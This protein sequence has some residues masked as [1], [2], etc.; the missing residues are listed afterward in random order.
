MSAL[1]TARIIGPLVLSTITFGIARAGTITVPEGTVTVTDAVTPVG[2]L[3]QYDYTI[4]DGTG[5]LAVLDIAVTPG[6]DISGL[7]APGGN[8]DFTSTV[9]TANTST[10]TEAFVSFL[11][12]N[13]TFTTAPESG[14]TFDSSVPPAASSFD[15]T[16]FDGT[17]GSGSIQAPVVAATPEP[18]SLTLCAILGAALLFGRKKLAASCLR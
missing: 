3:Y 14:F 9:D 10:G 5:Q 4:A 18:S 11:E 8:F 2:L 7:T 16:L 17:V 15:A 1:R 12:N 13:G 6:V